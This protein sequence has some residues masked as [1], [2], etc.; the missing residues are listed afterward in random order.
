MK[1]RMKCDGREFEGTPKEIAEAMQYLAFGRQGQSLDEYVDWL[2]R[3]I[4]R[5]TGVEVQVTADTQEER[6]SA[7]VETMLATD[8]AEAV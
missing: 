2:F 7:L 4:H 6:T 8:L 5:L 3:E 1:I